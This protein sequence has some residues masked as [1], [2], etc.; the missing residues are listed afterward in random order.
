MDKELQKKYLQKGEK[1]GTA[2]KLLFPDNL[3][4]GRGGD[5]MSN[6]TGSSLEFKDFRHYQPGDDLRNIDWNAYARSD[7]LIVKT[8]HKEVNPHIDIILD[9]SKSMAIKD[10][11]SGTAIIL[12]AILST[13]AA[14]SK[15]SHKLWLA[16][17]T[18]K[19]TGNSSGRPSNWEGINFNHNCPP[20]EA[21]KKMAPNFVHNSIRVL[22]S[23]LLWLEDPETVLSYFNHQAAS[24]IV[25]EVLTNS[26]ESPEFR[27]NVKF[28]DSESG[29]IIELYLDE[30]AAAD[31][32][33]KLSAHRDNWYRA[34]QRIGATM[35][36]L[37]SEEL[38][39]SKNLDKLLKNQ[40]LGVL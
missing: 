3:V 6:Q 21:Y 36:S 7:N 1:I 34:S 16:A 11:K 38:L 30:T 22:I 17:D 15:S 39:E 23:D 9:C 27:G 8:F 25:L 32:I 2:Y 5:K 29:E 20:T 24:I 14:N 12:A 10:E 40:I 13:A 35:I 19:E 28:E 31:Y 26:E 18:F 37:S 33:A 4:S